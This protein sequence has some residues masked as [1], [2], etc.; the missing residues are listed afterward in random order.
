MADETLA[1]EDV[2]VATGGWW[3]LLLVGLLS[4]AVG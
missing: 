3:L 2:R 4:I 1:Q